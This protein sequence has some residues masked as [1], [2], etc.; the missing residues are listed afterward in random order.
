MGQIEPLCGWREK[1]FDTPN[2]VDPFL[3]VMPPMREEE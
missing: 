1:E 2:G 3:A